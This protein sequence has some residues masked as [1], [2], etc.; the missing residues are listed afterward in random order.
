MILVTLV[1][2][3]K[4]VCLVNILIGVE[5]MAVNLSKVATVELVAEIQRRLNCGEKRET[6]TIFFGPPGKYDQRQFIIAL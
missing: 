2:I 1:P 5:E 3:S 4:S 6:R